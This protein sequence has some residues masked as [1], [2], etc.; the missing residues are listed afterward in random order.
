M[1]L[2][3]ISEISQRELAERTR[4]SQAFISLLANGRRG[5]G[6][7]SAWRIASA[8]GVRTEELFLLTGNVSTPRTSRAVAARR[9]GRRVAGARGV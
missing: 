9:E 1:E 4:L 8:L 5:A 6:P 3:R 2:L 7:V